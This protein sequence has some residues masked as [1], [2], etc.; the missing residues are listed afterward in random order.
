MTPADE[1]L[2]AFERAVI[3]MPDAEAIDHAERISDQFLDDDIGRAILRFHCNRTTTEYGEAE[4]AR[5]LLLSDAMRPYMLRR[6][7]AT[8]RVP[9]PHRMVDLRQPW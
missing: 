7:V 2:A 8:E 4:F 5:L 1:L 3:A 6:L 9:D